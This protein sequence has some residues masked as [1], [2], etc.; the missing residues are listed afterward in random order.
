MK[1]KASLLLICLSVLF[2]IFSGISYSA[3]IR[4]SFP[5]FRHERVF[6]PPSAPQGIISVNE[7]ETE[8]WIKIPGIGENLASAILEEKNK[9][10]PF[11]YPEDLLSVR[12]IGSSKLKMIRPWIFLD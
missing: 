4:K 3:G 7:A 2:C 10:G 12:G 11:Y 8:D 9:H 5:V 6:T 1:S